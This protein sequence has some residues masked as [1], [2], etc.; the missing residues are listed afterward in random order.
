MMTLVGLIDIYVLNHFPGSVSSSLI[1]QS[2]SSGSASWVISLL[3]FHQQEPQEKR[4]TFG[5]SVN[6]SSIQLTYNSY[7][8]RGVRI[9]LVLKQSPASMSRF[10]IC[11]ATS[12][13]P[14]H[15]RQNCGPA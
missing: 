1:G 7:T 14:S 3:R 6:T 13:L 9:S 12:H 2:G 5:G 8:P 11:L 15:Q 4:E 10:E